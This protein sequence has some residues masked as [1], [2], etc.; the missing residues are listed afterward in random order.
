MQRGRLRHARLSMEIEGVD[1][2][3]LRSAAQAAPTAGP[4]AVVTSKGRT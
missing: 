3:E 1:E 4:E 2:A